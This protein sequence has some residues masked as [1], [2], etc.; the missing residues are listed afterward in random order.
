MIQDCCFFNGKES[1]RL[2]GILI[3]RLNAFVVKRKAVANRQL[4]SLIIHRECFMQ[5]Q[6]FTTIVYFVL[7]SWAGTATNAQADDDCRYDAR[8]A[9]SFVEIQSI[10]IQTLQPL[11][12]KGK[13]NVPVGKNKQDKC[14]QANRGRPAVVVLHGSGGVDS[15]G[16]FY[17][18]A[19]NAKG[20]DTLEID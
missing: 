17:T 7:F 14:E 5:T 2:I 1:T 16:D 3:T 4:Y 19:L 15:R 20:I 10:D 13:L 6:T 8:P 11:T 9:I 12:V 18:R